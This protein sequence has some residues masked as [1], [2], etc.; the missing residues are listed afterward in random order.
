[1][2]TK[3][4]ASKDK[5]IYASLEEINNFEQVINDLETAHQALRKVAEGMKPVEN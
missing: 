5:A 2:D 3:L 1:M 4:E